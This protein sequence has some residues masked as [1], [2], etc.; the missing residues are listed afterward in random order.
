[1]I[2]WKAKIGVLVPSCNYIIEP[3]MYKMVSQNSGI[4]VHFARMFLTEDSEE[5]I[6]ALPKHA[7]EASIL[8]M[9]AAVDIIGFGCTAGSFVGGLDYDKK[10]INDIESI[11][12]IPVT[13]TSTALL[14][15]M[16]VAGAK[17][18]SIVTP[19]Q[20]WINEKE[21]AFLEQNG[22]KVLKIVGM[23][24][25]RKGQV[26]EIGDIFPEATYELCIKNFVPGSD[27]LFISCTG[28]RT[29]EII[30][31]LEEDLK[32]VVITSNQATLWHMLKK[33]NIST[34]S[35]E[36]WGQLMRR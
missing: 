8:L 6:K 22:I 27:A 23:N 35:L 34:K 32:T 21:K 25:G 26:P 24:L 1:M 30:R 4:T 28:F 7:K 12:N 10:I 33:L 13:T 14:E 11:T 5:E 17:K 36:C 18:I 29:I 19:Y 9:H 20:D 16:K 2:G 15:A 3:E 31:D